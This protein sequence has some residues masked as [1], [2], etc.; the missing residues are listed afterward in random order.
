[1]MS[2]SQEA[3]H[4]V[5]LINWPVCCVGDRSFLAWLTDKYMDRIALERGGATV[6]ARWTK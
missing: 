6:T 4:M 3:R 1:M 5:H 2:Q